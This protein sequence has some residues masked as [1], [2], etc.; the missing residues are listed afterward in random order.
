MPANVLIRAGN[1]GKWAAKYSTG[2]PKDVD[3]IISGL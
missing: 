2:K 3:L 1:K